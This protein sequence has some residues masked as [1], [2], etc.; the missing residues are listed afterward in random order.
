MSERRAKVISRQRLDISGVAG[1]PFGRTRDGFEQHWGIN[2]AG[3]FLLTHELLPILIKSSSPGF[4]SRIVN[5]TS[6]GHRLFPSHLQDHNFERTKYEPFSAYATSK[7]AIIYHSNYIDRQFSRHGVHAVAVHPGTI[8][9]TNLLRSLDNEQVTFDEI[10]GYRQELKSVSQGAATTVWAAISSSLEG[11]GGLY[12][13][14]CTIGRM[15]NQSM[16]PLDGGYSA[17]AFHPENEDLLWEE[18][19]KDLAIEENLV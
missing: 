17:S 9:D 12:L 13:E 1:V 6:T 4:A 14:N 8:R 18:T 5:I 2:Y 10:A 7:L 15:E 19:R 3:H 11:S 16:G